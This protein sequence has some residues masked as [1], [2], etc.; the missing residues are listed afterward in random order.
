MQS[1]QRKPTRSLIHFQENIEGFTSFRSINNNK[2]QEILGSLKG[3]KSASS[4][5]GKM[6]KAEILFNKRQYAKIEEFCEN[7]KKSQKEAAIVRLAKLEPLPMKNIKMT[8]KNKKKIKTTVGLKM[9]I[10]YA[11]YENNRLAWKPYFDFDAMG[12]AIGKK[13]YFIGG[14]QSV[15]LCYYDRD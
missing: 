13:G 1:E 2:I 5:I 10:N 14:R 9:D 12:I 7:K 6:V 11:I 15:P 4:N 3:M 8:E